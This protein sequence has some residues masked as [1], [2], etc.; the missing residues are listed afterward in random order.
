MGTGVPSGSGRAHSRKA[1]GLNTQPPR[2]PAAWG[3]AF[4][5]ASPL[6]GAPGPDCQGIPPRPREATSTLRPLTPDCLLTIPPWRHQSRYIEMTRVLG[7][8]LNQPRGFQGDR[9]H[10]RRAPH[11]LCAEWVWGGLGGTRA[12]AVLRTLHG[13]VLATQVFLQGSPPSSQDHPAPCR[14]PRGDEGQKWSTDSLPP[15][16]RSEG[17][18]LPAPAWEPLSEQ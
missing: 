18:L 4:P 2:G 5:S 8:V 9:E 15:N 6:R 3:T 12:P 7:S 14:C 1:G 10:S 17:L 16:S 11:T 13:A